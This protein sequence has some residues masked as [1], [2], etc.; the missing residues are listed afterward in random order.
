MIRSLFG[1]LMKNAVLLGLLAIVPGL[2]AQDAIPS[3]TIL[4]FQLNTS[5]KSNKVRAGRPIRA[6]LMQDVPLDGGGSI[7]AGATILGHVI[8][9]TPARKGNGAEISLRFDRLAVKSKPISVTTNLRA[10]ASLMDVSEAQ[11]PESG[12]DRGTSQYNWTTDQIG[13]EVKYRGGG[14]IARGSDIVGHS[15]PNGVLVRV[16]SK[17]G[18]KCRGEVDGND[19][20]QALWVFSSDACGLY[21][22]PDVTLAH[23][24]RTRPFGEII[25]RSNKGNVNI[26]AGS[27]M[28]L[29]VNCPMSSELKRDISSRDTSP[30]E[31]STIGAQVLRTQSP[32][33]HLS[34]SG[35][36]GSGFHSG[37]AMG[38]PD[39]TAAVVGFAEAVGATVGKLTIAN[40]QGELRAITM[41]SSCGV[42]SILGLD[43]DDDTGSGQLRR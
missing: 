16:S 10:L 14:A 42:V 6:R 30:P 41:E 21:D 11:I 23:A 33:W 8:A 5:L 38:A 29:R 7:H 24:G 15:V 31:T 22:F 12:P 1:D 18:T 40:L 27:G 39:S 3:G 32:P 13:G 2:F 17:P 43:A 35:I 25:L 19:R 36:S 37:P 34:R 26:R 4:P 28:L 20:L 9:V